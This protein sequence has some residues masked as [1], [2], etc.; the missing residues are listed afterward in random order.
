MIFQTT[1]NT[2]CDVK[3]CKNNAAFFVPAKGRPGRFYICRECFEKLC[4][5]VLHT[6]TPKSPKNTIKKIIE[7]KAEESARGID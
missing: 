6:V 2:K 5:D 1:E 4:G 7:Q 3:D